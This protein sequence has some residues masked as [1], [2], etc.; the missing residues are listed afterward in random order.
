M[1]QGHVYQSSSIDL[2]RT[3]HLPSS[4]APSAVHIDVLKY[5]R[6]RCIQLPKVFA[7]ARGQP[8]DSP[9]DLIFLPLRY[10]HIAFLVTHSIVPSRGPDV[11]TFILYL[12]H[13]KCL[14]RDRVSRSYG[15]GLGATEYVTPLGLQAEWTFL[16]ASS[17]FVKSWSRNQ[18]NGVES[19]DGFGTSAQVLSSR[20]DG[21]RPV[22][23]LR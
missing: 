5:C 20:A 4:I 8:V 23:H 19:Q 9:R 3:F 6:C 18:H 17:K 13:K 12:Y 1:H 15:E 7:T 22:A 11:L 16:K 21:L 14:T 10:L 2:I